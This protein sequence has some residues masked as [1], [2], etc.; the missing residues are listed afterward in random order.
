MKNSTMIEIQKDNELRHEYM[1]ML[2]KCVDDINLSYR[3]CLG[4]ESALHCVHE[5]G[6]KCAKDEFKTGCAY[7]FKI[8]KE[9]G[10]VPY[11]P[12]G[13]VIPI[14][15][16]MTRIAKWMNEHD[17]PLEEIYNIEKEYREYKK[18]KKNKN[19]TA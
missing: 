10:F 12:K 5:C 13:Y 15:H 9:D 16:A 7:C 3:A 18:K 19:K 14:I 6:D 4:G 17:I 8:R 11:Q 1:D 2:D